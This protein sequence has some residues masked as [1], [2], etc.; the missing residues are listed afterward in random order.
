M[1]NHLQLELT[2]VIRDIVAILGQDHFITRLAYAG[3]SG[4][5]FRQRDGRRNR[6]NRREQGYRDRRARRS[7]SDTVPQDS[8]RVQCLWR[9]VDP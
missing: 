8:G 1:L 7:N 3:W 4:N 2:L 5:H 9:G 6:H